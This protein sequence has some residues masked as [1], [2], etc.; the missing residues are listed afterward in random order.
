M[1]V[2]LSR[3][4]WILEE[5]LCWIVAKQHHMGTCQTPGKPWKQAEPNQSRPTAKTPKISGHPA[6]SS[7]LTSAVSLDCLLRDG[8][9]S[10]GSGWETKLA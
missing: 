5:D 6:M 1:T 4:F 3:F 2:T 7:K 9:L 8:S 10:T